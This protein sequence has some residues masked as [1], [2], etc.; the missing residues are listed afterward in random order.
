MDKFTARREIEDTAML[1]KKIMGV[2]TLLF[3][4]PNGFLYNGLAD[5]ALKQKDVVVTWS[6]DAGDWHKR[7]V[8]VERLVSCVVERAKPGD[9]ILM[10]DGGGDRS[11]TVQA[12]PEII[13]KLTQRGYQFVTVPEMLQIKDNELTKKPMV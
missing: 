12:L 9:I 2:K 7:G 5:Y 1:L 4:P 3:R 8:S 11:K 13:D 6:L 10:H